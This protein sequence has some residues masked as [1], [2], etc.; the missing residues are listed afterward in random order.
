LKNLFLI[1][2][3]FTNF[4]APAYSLF[5]DEESKCQTLPWTKE[6]S[7]TQGSGWIWFPGKATGEN[8]AEAYLKAEGAALG[9]LMQ[10]CNFPHKEV[11]I[12]ERC[13]ERLGKFYKAYIRISV[14]DK[15]CKETKYSSAEKA[16][17]IKNTVLL[18]TYQRY[19]RLIA[20]NTNIKEDFCNQT[21]HSKCLSLGK[22][23]FHM[24]N[25]PAALKYFDL[26][27]LHGNMDS[28]FNAG[29]TAKISG[30]TKTA[31]GHFKLTCHNSK[32]PDPQG[33]FFLGQLYSVGSAA[34]KYYKKACHLNIARACRAA[35]QL[36]RQKLKLYRKGCQ[37]KDR[38]SCKEVATLY[39]D[40]KN[41]KKSLTYSRRACTLGEKKSCK[42][43]KFLKKKLGQK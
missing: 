8:L 29:L 19:Q 3:I 9:R 36:S 25:Y 23:E 35:A 4:N 7:R 40:L 21:N 28:C 16:K 34:I 6:D 39:Y 27:C 22:Y 1:F 31:I 5:N 13:D 30:A 14:K 10:E 20:R 41:M 33:C 18:K 24:Q 2:V 26:G 37:L 11:K 17:T 38:K 12:H 15:F 42:N 32:K 43:I